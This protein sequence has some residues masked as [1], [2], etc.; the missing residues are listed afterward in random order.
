[1]GDLE[2]L[3]CQYCWLDLTNLTALRTLHMENWRLTYQTP[4]T[5]PWFSEMRALTTIQ[6][7]SMLYDTLQPS[8][9]I[10]L[11]DVTDTL[12]TLVWTDAGLTDK[13]PATL[14]GL[15]Q[16]NT[17]DL[18]S[19]PG[20]SVP[21]D[22]FEDNELLRVVRLSH[23][24]ALTSLPAALSTLHLNSLDATFCGIFTFSATD[25]NYLR[26]ERLSRLYA[27]G[28][29]FYCSC[30]LQLFLDW[31]RTSAKIA[32]RRDSYTCS[33][34]HVDLDHV[35]LYDCNHLRLLVSLPLGFVLLVSILGVVAYRYRWTLRWLHYTIKLKRYQALEEELEHDPNIEYDAFVSYS[36]CDYR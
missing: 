2:T 35:A 19:N 24:P 15:H 31:F 12:H 32:D 22:A 21:E 1:M 9:P 6:L 23:I 13:W 28:N 10:D 17:L 27:G 11:S 16:L 7:I 25:V 5:H 4:D 33:N 3:E 14:R 18:S 34:K 36:S 8:D 30:D 20:L 29:P 26:S